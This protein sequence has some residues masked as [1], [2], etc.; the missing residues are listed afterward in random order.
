MQELPYSQH[1]PLSSGFYVILKS[2]SM[3][4][5]LY[6]R[7]PTFNEML[8]KARSAESLG[9]WGVFIN[10]HVHGFDDEGREPYLEAW[11]TM[12]A[13]GALT[14]T[15]RIGHIVL[16]NSLRNPAYLAKSIATLDNITGGRYEV[17]IGA[18]WNEPEYIGYDLME[19]GRGMPSAKERVDRLID[20]LQILNLMLSQEVV[21]FEGKFWKLKGAINIP[22]P[23]QNP[24]RISVGCSKPRMLQV[25]ARYAQG[26]NIASRGISNMRDVLD[27]FKEAVEKTGK[28]MDDYMISGFDAIRIAKSEEETREMAKTLSERLNI[29]VD[30]VIEDYLIGTPETLIEKIRSLEDMGIDMM[31]LSPVFDHGDPIIQFKDRIMDQ[32]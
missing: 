26:L 19:K 22:Q 10:D 8:Q 18:G 3:K 2:H 25:T 7:S 31:V 13:I 4:F 28:N 6:I 17:L 20:S 29:P 1:I 14:K 16:F 11:T 21:D 32:V 9:Y 30:K 15:I 12:T 27:R 23:I 24:M 5:G